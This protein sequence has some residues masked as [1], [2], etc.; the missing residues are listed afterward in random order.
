MA[1]ELDETLILAVRDGRINDV[2]VLLGD[3]ANP[4]FQDSRGMTALITAAQFGRRN[5]LFEMLMRPGLN[6]N[7]IDPYFRK[8]AIGWARWNRFQGIVDDLNNA[9]AAVRPQDQEENPAAIPVW[10]EPPDD[11]ITWL[12]VPT[13]VSRIIRSDLS[14]QFPNGDTFRWEPFENGDY[15]CLNADDH[16]IF[17]IDDING[18]WG[19]GHTT[20]PLTNLHITQNDI[21]RITYIHSLDSQ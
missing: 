11:P 18:W 1:N 2:Q 9:G 21:E 5:I 17:R 4:N 7:I 13:T 16:C 8:T 15:V 3:G 12:Y 14:K 20:N 10:T 19:L 6:L